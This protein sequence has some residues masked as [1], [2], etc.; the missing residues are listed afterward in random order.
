MNLFLVSFE[1]NVN[2]IYFIIIIFS[3]WFQQFTNIV[4][5][6][7]NIKSLESIFKMSTRSKKYLEQLNFATRTIDFYCWNDQFSLPEQLNF[8]TGAFVFHCWNNK[9]SLQEQ[10]NFTTKTIDCH[11]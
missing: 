10:L 6:Y 7:Y 1:P 8:T 2:H 11:C 5:S 3:A 4:L 9:F